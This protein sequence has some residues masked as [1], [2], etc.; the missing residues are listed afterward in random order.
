MQSNNRPSPVVAAQRDIVGD[1]MDVLEEALIGSL[2]IM[3]L[4]GF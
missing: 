1:V 3:E 2:L 4:R